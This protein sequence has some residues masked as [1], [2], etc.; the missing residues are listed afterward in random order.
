MLNWSIYDAR[1]TARTRFES[2]LMST[3]AKRLVPR[4]DEGERRR[5]RDAGRGNRQHNPEDDAEVTRAVDPGGV[6]EFVRDRA[7][8]AAQQPDDEGKVDGAVRDD[9]PEERVREMEVHHDDEERDD[10]QDAR[11]ELDEQHREP[12][13]P[14][15]AEV[16]PCERV[17]AHIPARSTIAVVPSETIIEFLNWRRNGI[18]GDVITRRKLSAVTA[19]G[20]RRGCSE[21][22]AARGVKAVRSIQ[23]K[24][25]SATTRK[26]AK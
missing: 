15:P 4:V 5:R 25:N 21:K 9:Q 19:V 8:V 10:E 17:R 18:V 26:S 6:L 7:E 24:G 12:E 11:K 13:G 1:P 23:R 20:T 14:F 2:S 3:Y 16:Q 22:A